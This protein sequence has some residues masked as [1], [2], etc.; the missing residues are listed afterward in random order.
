MF[1]SERRN[2]KRKFDS[3]QQRWEEVYHKTN[4]DSKGFQ[5]RKS[6]AVALCVKHL[7]P[8]SHILDLGCGCGHASTTLAQLGYRV[9]GAD[10]SE[11]MI[12]QAAGNARLMGLDNCHFEVFDF[13]NDEPKAGQFDGLIALGF[14]EDFD[15]PVWVLKKMHKLLKR[16]GVAMVQIWNRRPLGDTVLSPPYR[17]FS[18]IA[19]PL[20]LLKSLAKSALPKALVRRLAKSP[21]MR[22]SRIEVIH[23]RYTADELREMAEEAGF[24][25]IDA[26]G[27][28]FFPS[29]FFFCDR[30]RVHWDE[31]LQKWTMDKPF[32]QQRAIDYVGALKK[33]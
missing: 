29:K 14:L 30:R 25:V 9:T 26:R 1:Q 31:R 17:L 16:D 27:S 11:P 24:K 6:S 15:D 13:V 7:P 32:I 2:I 22:P 12:A 18:T 10:L 23:R 28:R 19:H 8:G 21:P 20:R 5:W 33:V 4:Y 3:E